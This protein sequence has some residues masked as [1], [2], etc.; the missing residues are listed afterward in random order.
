[1]IPLFIRK[2][3]SEEIVA[4]AAKELAEHPRCVSVGGPDHENRQYNFVMRSTSAT[5]WDVEVAL[6]PFVVE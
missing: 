5:P 6:I 4:K 3:R 2:A 1:M